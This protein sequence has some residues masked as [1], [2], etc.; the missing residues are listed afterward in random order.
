MKWFLVSIATEKTNLNMMNIKDTI[1][2]E[3]NIGVTETRG[4]AY[5]SKFAFASNRGIAPSKVD[6]DQIIVIGD[7]ELHNKRE[8][9]IKY[10][11]DKTY[12]TDEDLITYL[13]KNKG[14]EFIKDLIGEFSFILYDRNQHRIYA[15]R[16]P[17]GI[18]S[19][20]WMR[21]GDGF[22]FASDIF[23]LKSFF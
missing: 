6:F 14:I 22:I 11:L 7:I 4:E 1:L 23:L 20:Y 13:Y 2:K 17:L 3:F 5:N 15:V 16:D 8:I 9:T 21:Y 19:L 12:L 18:K 10:N